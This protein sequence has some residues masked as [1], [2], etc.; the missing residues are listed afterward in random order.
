M[1][2][3]EIL[4]ERAK[5]TIYIFLA[6]ILWGGYA[7]YFYLLEPMKPLEIIVWRM[8]SSLIFCFLLL[9]VT[10]QFRG[11]F[12]PLFSLKHALLV[13]AGAILAF[14]NWVSFLIAIEYRLVVESSMGGFMSPLIISLLGVIFLRERMRGLQW[15]SLL[16]C[17][18][19]VTYLVVSYGGVPFIAL[20]QATTWS[21]YALVRKKLG[22]I[23]TPIQTMSLES[24]LLIPFGCIAGIWVLTHGGFTFGSV[25]NL[26]TILAVLSGVA[27]IIPLLFFVASAKRIPFITMGFA[28]Y[29]APILS[30]LT[31]IYIIG[32]D[33]PNSRWLSFIVLWG[34]VII[35]I[36]DSVREFIKQK[37][38]V[39]S[40]NRT[41]I[42]DWE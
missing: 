36:I 29:T 7:L 34:A 21:L 33:M 4:S 30:F 23:A 13:C 6:Y 37:Q 9:G 10:R 1:S 22:D 2:A 42:T 24:T 11:V 31:G 3:L 15:L 35:L 32:E 14:S 38:V 17:A 5:G 39:K 20:L 19:S 27:A 40:R 8:V 28:Q 41:I 12:R 18:I 16:V 26:N 25:S